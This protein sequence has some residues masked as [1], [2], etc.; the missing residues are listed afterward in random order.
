MVTGRFF[1]PLKSYSCL[2]GENFSRSKI[3]QVP[4]KRSLNISGKMCQESKEIHCLLCIA[5]R[6]GGFELLDLI[7]FRVVVMYFRAVVP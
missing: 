6:E 2:T 5:R 1:D 7:Y 4:C 3:P